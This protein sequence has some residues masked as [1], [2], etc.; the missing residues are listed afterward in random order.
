MPDELETGTSS[1]PVEEP[2]TTPEG[3]APPEPKL[4]PEEDLRRLQAVKDREVTAAKREA[5]AMRQRLAAMEAS[6]ETLARQTMEPQDAQR[7]VQERR[8]QR[9]QADLQQQAGMARKYE[10]IFRMSREND[11]PITKFEAVLANSAAKPE[12]AQKVVTDFWREK[13]KAAE[14][15]A[16]QREQE[17]AVTVAKVQ[18]KERT[19]DGSDRIGTPA[20]PAG[21]SPDLEAQYLEEKSKLTNAALRGER[22]DWLKKFVDLKS[23][24]RKLGLDI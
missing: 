17:A 19:E 20:E 4:V 12:D 15:E 14:R 2:K 9:Q 8:G 18:R 21:G 7:F 5:D 16:K 1:S 6:M 22:G 13:V 24:Y 3:E 10:D 11:V 23:K